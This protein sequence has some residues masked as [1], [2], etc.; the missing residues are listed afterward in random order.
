MSEAKPHIAN[1]DDP[2]GAYRK[3]CTAFKTWRECSDTACRRAHRCVGDSNACFERLWPRVGE[4]SKV[5]IRTG[6]RALSNGHSVAEA[7]RMAEAEVAR[8][9]DHI[10]RTDAATLASI[11]QQRREDEEKR[12][13]APTSTN[14]AR[15]PAARP[16]AAAGSGECR[17][18]PTTRSAPRS[19]SRPGRRNP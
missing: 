3:L 4:E 13:L 16:D 17:S 18:D 2:H 5:R 15:G 8:A 14:T 6:I 19:C 11:A 1:D 7:S 12:K 10:A 9:A